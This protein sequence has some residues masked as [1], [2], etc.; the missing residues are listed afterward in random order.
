M[1]PI[2]LK[3][4][5]EKLTACIEGLIGQL[6]DDFLKG[7]SVQRIAEKLVGNLLEGKVD[8]EHTV[9]DVVETVY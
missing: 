1:D 7:G 3:V 2:A 9:C 6:E 4:T 5:N 8:D